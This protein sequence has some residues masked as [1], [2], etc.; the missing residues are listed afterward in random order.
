MRDGWLVEF[1]PVRSPV[2]SVQPGPEVTELIG[3][4]GGRGQETSLND[5]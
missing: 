4:T 3:R 2:N 1:G 5:Q